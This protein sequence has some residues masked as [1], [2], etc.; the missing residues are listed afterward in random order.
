M[1]IDLS[2]LSP[3]KQ[4]AS[5]YIGYYDRAPDAEGLEFWVKQY[6]DGM[7]LAA[8]AE[9]FS[10][11]FETVSPDYAG[12]SYF[13]APSSASAEVFLSNVYVNLV[14]RAPDAEGLAFW[15]NLLENDPNYTPGRIILD[16][17]GGAQSPD[18]EKILNKIDVAHD[19]VSS[20]ADEGIS[21]PA[22]P[23]FEAAA[24]GT[25]TLLDEAAYNS[26]R[27]VL[28]G[29]DET[30]A[31]VDA[32]KGATDA[33]VAGYINEAPEASD[34]V[35]S[36]NEDAAI[37]IDVVANDTDVDG[38]A[39]T[40]T[41]VGAA[42]NGT[43]T[44]NG[45]GT[46]TYTPDAN[47]N[48][49]DSFTYEV[50]DGKGGTDSATVTV[51]VAAQN[52]APVAAGDSASTEEEAAVTIDVLANDSDIDGDTLTVVGATDGAN[53]SVVIN[54]DGTV[55]YTPNEDFTGTDSF[56]YEVSDGTV[57]SFS[58][59]TVDVT[60]PAGQTF[61]LTSG[62]D[63]GPDFTGGEGDDTFLANQG[64]LN[65]SDNLD[66]GGAGSGDTDTLK[67]AVQSGAS[68]FE[69]APTLSNIEE[70]EVNGPNL[71]PNQDITIDLSNANGYETLRSF[72]TTAD[73]GQMQNGPGPIQTQSQQYMSLMPLVSFLD[74]QNV[75]GTDLEIIDTNA[76]H[77]FTYDSNAFETLFA[78]LF[79][80]D[81]AGNSDDNIDIL[82]QEV[83][84]STI[85]IELENPVAG[86][87]GG[88]WE[89]T[90]PDEFRS[91]VDS[92][93]I[94]SQARSQV[95][96]TDFNYVYDLNVGPVFTTL[97]VTGN[98]DFEIE[99]FLEGPSWLDQSTP[100]GG[101]NT[102][103]AMTLDGDLTLDLVGQG[104]QGLVN[105]RPASEVN[106]GGNPL[107]ASGTL[108][109]MGAIGDNDID[110]RG[111]TNGD[112]TFQGGD[113]LLRV[114]NASDMGYDRADVFGDLAVRMAAGNDSVILN[115]TGEQTVS[116]GEGD[117]QLEI[118]GD[119]DNLSNNVDNDGVSSIDAGAG[120]DTVT[121]TGTG[122]DPELLDND[123]D[124]ILGAGDD[125]LTALQGGEHT[126]DGG[127]GDDAISITGNGNNEV[128]SGEGNDTVTI[129]GDADENSGGGQTV[130]TGA[131]DDRVGITG[132][133]NQV[134]SLGE[135][136]DEGRIEGDGV[137]NIDMGAGNDSFV[138]DGSRLTPN[139]IDNTTEDRQTTVDG[140]TGNDF[141]QVT[142]D[143]YLLVDM[144]EGD[145]TV[146]LNANELTVDDAI[147]GN[148]GIDTMVLNNADRREIDGRV[149]ESET[150]SATSFE[151][152]DLRDANIDLDLTSD[153]FDTTE[154]GKITVVTTNA[155]GGNG[156]LPLIPVAIGPDRALLSQGMTFAEF[157]DAANDSNLG[158]VQDLVDFLEDP[159]RGF[160]VDFEDTNENND[161]PDPAQ[162]FDELGDL[163]FFESD[164]TG[165]HT[166]DLT[167][168]PLSVA[169]GRS[170][171]LQ[172]G[173]IRDI[174][175]ADDASISSRLVL[176]YD[177]SNDF[178]HSTI[179]TLQVIDEAQI[180]AAD[181]RNVNGLEI[182]ELL[183]ASNDAQIW[184]IE[185]NDRVVNQT[186]GD[187]PLIIR[188]DPDVPAG[189]QV[190]IQLDSSIWGNTA[191]ND[192][193]IENVA[194]AEIYVD[195]GDGN[196]PQ[197]VTEPQYGADLLGLYGYANPLNNTVTV[198]ER[199]LFTQN[200]DSLVGTDNNDTF[201]VDSLS[202]IQDADSADG[203]G[204]I[205]DTL[206]F[207]NVTVSNQGQSLYDQIDTPQLNGIEIFQFDTGLNVQMTGLGI[208]AP[209]TFPT[210]VI[211]GTGDDTLLNMEGGIGTDYNEGYFLNGGNDFLR[212]DGDDND[213]YV[214]GGAGDDEVAVQEEDDLFGTDIELV[215]LEGNADANLRSGNARIEG[216]TMTV[217]GRPGVNTNND[218]TL[219]GTIL[220]AGGGTATVV[221]ED[222]EFVEDSADGL[223]PGSNNIQLDNE[224]AGGPDS[225][226]EVNLNGG[227]DTLTVTNVDEL[228]VTATD[229]DKEVSV[230]ETNPF[231]SS[232]ETLNYTGG[233]GV[234][235]VTAV[236]DGNATVNGNGDNDILDVTT[237]DGGSAT[238][239]GGL[240]NDSITVDVDNDAVVDGGNGDDTITV[241][242]EVDATVNGGNGN[243]T[244]EV[245]LDGTAA[246]DAIV[247]GGNG[248]DSITVNTNGNEDSFIDTG[249]GIDTVQL[250]VDADGGE[251]QIIFGDIVY[252]ALQ[253]VD[254][255][256]TQNFTSNGVNND[257]NWAGSTNDGFD[258]IKG[259]NMEGG[260]A[261]DEDVL[262]VS[263]F[264]TDDAGGVSTA[265]D[266]A[267]GDWRGTGEVGNASNL[268][269]D[270]AFGTLDRE[271]AVIGVDNNFVLNS[272]HFIEDDDGGNGIEIDDD[273]GRVVV[274][275]KDMNNDGGFDMAE[276]WFVQDIDDDAGLAL[277]IDK[278]AEV[279]FATDIGAITSID[280]DNFEF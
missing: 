44:D 133:G 106:G 239:N 153:N 47:F 88:S 159:A 77:L 36:T 57:S 7:S 212:T 49:T 134:V 71:D 197:L 55:T 97:N 101:V 94:D 42:A 273:G 90:T 218:V 11:Q 54:G 264:I 62:T 166:V 202:K 123:Y 231:F 258:V 34:D 1:P 176:D 51:D 146:D 35:D 247:N 251:D 151:I 206:L 156:A 207:D 87:P 107:N 38:D 91:H 198:I 256:T 12:Y 232:V 52:D 128:D 89:T 136:D 19:W 56:T 84:G 171:E 121:L 126:V 24:D 150:S 248:D 272:T 164:T 208:T 2:T 216:G 278:V 103:N 233:N 168:I 125:V 191:T 59:V 269:W 110:V 155:L 187:A 200:T 115:I 141:L 46:V 183:S 83:D 243:D 21:T 261:G 48:G 50:S 210:T 140:G 175:V 66:G 268:E 30:Q 79:V 242:A 180:T 26:A 9:E 263:N 45:D 37:T 224:R 219:T 96:T 265:A 28:D 250:F 266:F 254:G 116:L 16:M 74:I 194:N 181:L 100:I 271:I 225:D 186:T 279:E 158:S 162:P 20:A 73:M 139:N 82:L 4:I 124:I 190:R 249:R 39:L 182:I 131:G 22:N 226:A 201:I 99:R 174:I 188:V 93:S 61:V 238:V 60:K 177:F 32:A 105:N 227:N 114:G 280:S 109:V 13:E 221:L 86:T 6:N 223:D 113:D 119:V 137:H 31:S 184:D 199:L 67:L 112:F 196:G 81:P 70:I 29:V 143:H 130:V 192:V 203:A 217:T 69:A 148:T 205:G 118:N 213:V 154:N 234:D 193:I 142:A 235:S 65:S 15:K 220:A 209:S 120:N 161:K 241:N 98:A 236:V 33:F 163:V 259:F 167:G 245:T 178:G 260:G 211:T 144:G 228:I 68:D 127:A 276:I 172:G 179:D 58:T 85:D 147:D 111:N 230:G 41:S 222:I 237:T 270:F 255:S 262:N 64:T 152:F 78:G 257:P 252:T 240:G 229:G 75:N 274:V 117:D 214:D 40:I 17:I 173:T 43:V 104:F 3:A 157:V 145:D 92:I 189:S 53:G 27:S 72:Q 275:A 76:N 149:G 108:T 215:T 277:A 267:F 80:N 246:D 244:I 122:P 18:R 5:L 160:S 102:V 14:G 8:I 135:G 165:H 138:I 23:M 195:F 132:D 63:A 10:K 185:L 25:L 169:S 253:E 170:F 129:T 95:N 204:G